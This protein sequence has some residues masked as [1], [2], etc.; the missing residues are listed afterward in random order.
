[1]KLKFV[2]QRLV[3]TIVGIIMLVPFMTYFSP[4][5]RPSRET[6]VLC[7]VQMILVEW[8]AL[9]LCKLGLLVVTRIHFQALERT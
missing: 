7:A 3:P 1:M 6:A 8:H 9:D 2:A 5:H 4:R